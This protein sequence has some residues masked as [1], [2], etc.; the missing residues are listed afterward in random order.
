MQLAYGIAVQRTAVRAART[1]GGE[2]QVGVALQVPHYLPGDD[3]HGFGVAHG[4]RTHVRIEPATPRTS[5]STSATCAVTLRVTVTLGRVPQLAVVRSRAQD[6]GMRNGRYEADVNGRFVA[7]DLLPGATPAAVSPERRALPMVAAQSNWRPAQ[8]RDVAFA[9]Q[10]RGYGSL[11]DAGQT[12]C[13]LTSKHM[14]HAPRACAPTQTW[15]HVRAAPE[16]PITLRHRAPSA[17]A[18]PRRQL[19]RASGF[20]VR[21]RRTATWS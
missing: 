21:R 6:S 17:A 2:L 11:A 7:A 8:T 15:A 14:P 20:H 1:A 5:N 9:L 10:V 3:R 18:R 16:L 4:Q 19:R 13:H 12:S